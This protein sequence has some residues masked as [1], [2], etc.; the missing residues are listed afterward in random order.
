MPVNSIQTIFRMSRRWQKREGRVGEGLDRA[1]LKDN[2][3][4]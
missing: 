1:F 4:R 3:K 2:V